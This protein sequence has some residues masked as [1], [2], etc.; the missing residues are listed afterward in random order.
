MK[1]Y[2]LIK[3]DFISIGG[4]KLYRIQALREFDVIEKGTLGGYIQKESNLSHDGNCWVYGNARV[5]GNA[6][7]IGDAYV[8][9]D[10]RV[11]G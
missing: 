7:V 1:K 4:N 9:G 5:S 11:Y 2:K 3:N 6:L 10:A 8:S